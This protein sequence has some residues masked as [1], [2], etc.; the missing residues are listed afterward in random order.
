M[1]ED[2]KLTWQE[3]GEE[4]DRMAESET[5]EVVAEAESFLRGRALFTDER[6]RAAL[7]EAERGDRELA[8]AYA[9]LPVA[10]ALRRV[11][12]ALGGAGG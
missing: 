5:R 3:V 12:D 6:E 10:H 1:T 4:Y 11:A 9:M 7:A 8:Q 2:R